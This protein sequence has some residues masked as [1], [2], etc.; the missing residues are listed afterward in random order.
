MAETGEYPGLPSLREEDAGAER[1]EFAGKYMPAWY[2]VDAD[3]P[4]LQERVRIESVSEQDF[5]A[6]MVG[7]FSEIVDG[8]LRSAALSGNKILLE[9]VLVSFLPCFFDLKNGG[10]FGTVSL[11]MDPMDGDG[12]GD[13][14]VERYRDLLKMEKVPGMQRALPVV[15]QAKP[16]PVKVEAVRPPNAVRRD[17]LPLVMAGAFALMVSAAATMVASRQGEAGGPGAT[18]SAE[19]LNIGK[20]PFAVFLENSVRVF[21]PTD[22]T[23]SDRMLKMDRVIE[24]LLAG[25]FKYLATEMGLYPSNKDGGAIDGSRQQEIYRFTLIGKLSGHTT[26]T[27][28]SENAYQKTTLTDA[29]NTLLE[30]GLSDAQLKTWICWLYET[31]F[32]TKLVKERLRIE[33]DEKGLFKMATYNPESGFEAKKSLYVIEQMDAKEG[34]EP[35]GSYSKVRMDQSLLGAGN[36][37]LLPSGVSPYHDVRVPASL[38]KSDPQVTLNWGS[39]AWPISVSHLSSRIA[40]LEKRVAD[41]PDRTIVAPNVFGRSITVANMAPLIDTADPMVKELV[42]FVLTGIDKNNHPKRIQEIID[43]IQQLPY[44]LEYDSN[45]DRPGLL[46]LFNEG[47]DCNNVVDLYVQM[48]TAA[49]YDAAVMWVA[50]K[51]SKSDLHARGGVPA[52]YFPKAAGRRWSMGDGEE[53]LPVELTGKFPVGLETWGVDKETTFHMEVV[54][55]PKLVKEVPQRLETFEVVVPDGKGGWKP[56]DFGKK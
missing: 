16:A 5:K 36:R 3:I 26:A 52:K 8:E 4:D 25:K 29:V 34:S 1:P 24:K 31:S 51:N 33:R 9:L 37:L 12:A 19:V 22:L 6:L 23:K 35:G 7:C 13:L 47:G 10:S 44:K 48:M 42:D 53:W 30:P 39:G 11:T 43:F 46:V 55:A 15:D 28:D 20:K 50:F 49:G 2:Q 41:N 17:P 14:S 54:R 21:N 40:S 45:F 32:Y 56:L 38:L 18:E 27:K